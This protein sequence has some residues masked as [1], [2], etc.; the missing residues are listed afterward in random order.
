MYI[1][2]LLSVFGIGVAVGAVIENKR[3]AVWHVVDRI[4][5]LEESIQRM[6]GSVSQILPVDTLP[7]A[8]EVG[9]TWVDFEY[10]D[11]DATQELPKISPLST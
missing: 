11:P 4:E 8:E 2:V 5:K 9:G 10:K 3:L 1:A 7:V 6:N